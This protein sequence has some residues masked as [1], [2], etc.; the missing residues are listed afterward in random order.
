[1]PHDN[2]KT[3]KVSGLWKKETSTGKIYFTGKIT[4]AQLQEAVRTTG[5]LLSD[6]GSKVPT[7]QAQVTLKAWVNAEKFNERS[8][9]MN[10][11]LE[12]PYKPEEESRPAPGAKSAEMTEDDIPF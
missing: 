12:P 11:T 9:D 8:P 3:G 2:S 7:D 1:M 10:L 6:N 5:V 4:V